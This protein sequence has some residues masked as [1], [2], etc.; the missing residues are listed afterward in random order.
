MYQERDN[1]THWGPFY[2]FMWCGSIFCLTCFFTAQLVI[3]ACPFI[4]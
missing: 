3:K 1:I 2:C 4:E